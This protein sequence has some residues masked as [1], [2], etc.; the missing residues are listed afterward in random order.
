METKSNSRNPRTENQQTQ[1]V[2]LTNLVTTYQT[3]SSFI[4]G[5]YSSK[6]EN[7][8]DYNMFIKRNL[9]MIKVYLGKTE[10]SQK[11]CIVA[12]YNISEGRLMSIE[13]IALGDVLRTS[14]QVPRSF[15]IDDE[16]TV[17]EVSMALLRANPQMC[18]GDQ[19]S[20]LHLVQHAPS[21]P[22]KGVPYMTWKQ[23]DFTLDTISYDAIHS[24]FYNDVP[25]SLFRVNEGHIETEAGIEMGGVAYVLSREV[26]RKMQISTQSIVL[27]PDNDVYK[28][29]SSEEKKKEAAAS[30]R[31]GVVAK[32]KTVV[33]KKAVNPKNEYLYGF[34]SRSMEKIRMK[35]ILIALVLLFGI[36]IAAQN[37]TTGQEEKIYTQRE[38]DL[39]M[40]VQEQERKISEMQRS[41]EGYKEYIQNNDYTLFMKQAIIRKLNDFFALQPIEKAWVFGSYSRGEETRKSDMDILVRFDHNANITLFKYA[42]MVN[43]LQELLHKKIDLV[44]EGQLKDFAG[45]SADTDKILIYERRT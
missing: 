34:I 44:E 28:E 3:L 11:A 30:Y 29:Y 40:Q 10:A 21:S 16:T 23:Y 42:G 7:L 41:V 13:V 31:C 19:I 2:Q 14:L 45:E 6:P 27:T 35:K 22:G 39:M 43:S 9:N 17:D 5:A 12:P 25:K 24:E 36:T 37:N 26:G 15:R 38:V 8:S 4:R 1:R 33:P 20:I 18:E 32:K